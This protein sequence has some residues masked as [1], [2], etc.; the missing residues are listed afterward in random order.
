M[1][2]PDFMRVVEDA[3]MKEVMSYRPDCRFRDRLKNFKARLRV[4]S[5][6]R[7]D[8]QKEKLENL[9]NEAMR[10][11][12]EAEKRP[13]TEGDMSALLEVRKQWRRRNNKSNLRGLMVDG[14]WCEDPKVIKAEMARCFKNLFLDM[15]VIRPV[16][17]NNKIVKISEGDAHMPEKSDLVSTVQ[18]FWDKME[19]LNGCNAFFITIIPQERV[20]RVVGNVVGEVQNAFTKGRFILDGVFIANETLEFLK[21][22]KEKSLIF[23][24]DFEKAY[25]NINWRFLLDLMKRIGFGDCWI[26]VVE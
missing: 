10:W 25:D 19:I 2:E 1:D 15:G 8:G 13:L 14:L 24:V 7:F 6:D 5:K 4:W 18:W 9:S 16:F 12:L 21:K 20:K 11:E 3:W 17:C 23:K 22:K 26:M